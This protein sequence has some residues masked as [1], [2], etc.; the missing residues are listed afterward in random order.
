MGK[1]REREGDGGAGLGRKK[2]GT[3]N[4]SFSVEIR[5]EAEP[6]TGP[7]DKEERMTRRFWT[8]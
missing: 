1:E 8:V 5:S 4:E 7:L 6:L 3:N 2:E